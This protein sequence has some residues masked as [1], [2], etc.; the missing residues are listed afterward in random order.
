[1]PQITQIRWWLGHKQSSTPPQAPV[2]ARKST[3]LTSHTG[4]TSYTRNIDHAHEMLPP[5]LTL[6]IP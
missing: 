6:S 4:P 2:L 5:F 3:K 1:M